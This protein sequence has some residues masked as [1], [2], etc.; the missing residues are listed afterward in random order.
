MSYVCQIA[1]Y[2]E[3]VGF[4]NR[5]LGFAMAAARQALSDGYLPSATRWNHL[6]QL[7]KD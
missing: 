1:L 3:K 4:S 7:S 2:Q 6:E 5:R